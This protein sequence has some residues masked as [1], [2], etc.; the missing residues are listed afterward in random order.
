MTE[1]EWQKAISEVLNTSTFRYIVRFIR[2]YLLNH[3]ENIGYLNGIY[4]FFNIGH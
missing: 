3:F 1:T 2:A 4:R